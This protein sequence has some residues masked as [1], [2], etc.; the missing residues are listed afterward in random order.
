M[1][2]DAP[3]APFHPGPSHYYGD[4]VRIL[5][6][7]GAALIFLSD[8][9]PGPFLTPIAS[10]VI[11]VL[12]IV[13][14]GLTNPVQAWIHWINVLFSGLLLILFGS[15]AVARYQDTGMLALSTWLILVLVFIFICAL[16]S[17]IKTLR[18]VLM[19]GA[20]TIR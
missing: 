19:R 13:A 15:I 11:S 14:A 2:E 5:F 17:S 10:L 9:L 4:I 1:S 7:V 3:L 6:V 18:G 20:P 16:Y 12:L 8:F